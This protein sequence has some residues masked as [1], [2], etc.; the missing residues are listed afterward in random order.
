MQY[1]EDKKSGNRLSC[2][3]FGL[4]RLPGAVGVDVDASEKL[5][6]R[7][8]DEGVNYFDTAYLYPGSEDAL[9]Q[10]MERNGIRDRMYVAT[11]LPHSRCKSIDDVERFFRTSL[12][13]LRTDYVDYFLIH[14]VV[15][16]DQWQRLC[17]LGIEDWIAAHKADGSIR[18]IGF[19]F[20]GTLPEF[21]Q[22]MDAYD[23]DFVQIQYNY[24]N[25]HYQA[26]RE[27]LE[28]A[29]SRDMPVMIMEPLMGGKLATGLPK[30]ATAALAAVEP[31]RTP[32][33]WG[34]RWLWDQP[35]VS[36]VLS[37]MNS[38]EQLENNLAAA[39]AAHPGCMAD[40]E[41]DAIV[42]AKAALEKSFKVPCTG[43]NY[44]MPCPK[45]IS[46]PAMFSAYNASFSLGWFTG[47]YQYATSVGANGTNAHL[48]SDCVKC[49]A[50]AKKCP[51]HIDIPAQLENARKR[52]EPAP[53][54]VGIRAFSKMQ[55]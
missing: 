29:Q 45:G 31:S 12:K 28:L 20:H 30:Q 44:C 24:V 55:H 32:A 6:L 21:Q 27:G 8:L 13:R 25:E 11:K 46:I 34:L 3:G 4:M 38:M 18:Q 23:W 26:G 53:V 14:N 39:D 7:A 54:R 41:R 48:I 1:R 42:Q 52:L 49:G 40:A 17:E 22:V 5:V 19:S 33:E 35:G 36:V 43:C 47:M 9:G 10:I 50:C 15:S 16:A 37:G 2:L 51:Q